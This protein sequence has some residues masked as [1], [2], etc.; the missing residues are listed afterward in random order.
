M[1]LNIKNETTHELVRRL[2]ALTGQSQTGA[3]EDAVRRRLAELEQS[4]EEEIERKRAAIDAVVAR[5]R[6][7]P[8]TGRTTEEIMDELYDEAG[9]PR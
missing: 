3:V 1:S 5:A 9:M 2:A 8:R 6:L 7:I 4:R